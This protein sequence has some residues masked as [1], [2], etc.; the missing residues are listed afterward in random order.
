MSSQ[1]LA[2]AARHVG[3]IGAGTI[4]T[5]MAMLFVSRGLSVALYDPQPAVL[6]N[7]ARTL[8]QASI[9]DLRVTFADSVEAATAGAH[10]VFEAAPER[11]EL[12]RQLYRELDEVT[13]ENVVIATGTSSLLVSDI[14]QGLAHPQR[15]I[16]AHPFNPPHLVPLVEICGGRETSPWAVDWGYDFFLA[17]GR[18][19][20]RL[21]KE[22][23]GHIANRLS[24][25]LYREAV[26][27]VSAGIASVRDVD[28]AVRF[29]P[30]LRW[31]VMGPHLLY[32]LAAGDGG[33]AQ[34]LDHL[35]PTQEAR[36]K[37]LGDPVLSLPLKQEL[38]AGVEAEA[39]GRDL[40]TLRCQRDQ[41]LIAI[42]DVLKRQDVYAA[43]SEASAVLEGRV[44]L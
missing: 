2:K 35:G 1:V 44:E 40:A 20:I 9:V 13:P 26:H 34:Y 23:V 14:Q 8:K 11:L 24:A 30:G 5:S 29:G 32:H 42:L 28:D 21:R 10:F 4:G 15:V 22:A 6:A 31:A 3:V 17:L 33:Y 41:A 38:V 39:A 19:P 16:A 27:L 7:T 36:W 12:K 18:K 25:A 37:D 43:S